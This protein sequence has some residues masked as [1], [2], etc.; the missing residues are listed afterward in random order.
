MFHVLFRIVHSAVTCQIYEDVPLRLHPV[1]PRLCV[2]LFCADSSNGIKE[3]WWDESDTA[4]AVS[5]RVC[6]RVCVLAHMR[7]RV[8]VGTYFILLMSHEQAETPSIS[9]VPR[10]VGRTYHLPLQGFGCVFHIGAR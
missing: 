5:K 3:Q 8:F 4:V 1:H 7:V 9:S 2:L 10:L 6:L